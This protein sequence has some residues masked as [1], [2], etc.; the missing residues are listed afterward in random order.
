MY[1]GGYGAHVCACMAYGALA[2]TNLNFF[3]A[4][5]LEILGLAVANTFW[6]KSTRSR[7]GTWVHTWSMDDFM[8]L[9]GS[10]LIL[11]EFLSSLSSQGLAV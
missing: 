5:L 7:W 3:V 2:L 1:R 8:D 10:G 6:S 11:H 9:H 4:E